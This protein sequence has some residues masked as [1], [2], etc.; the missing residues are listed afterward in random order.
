V[1]SSRH[2]LNFEHIDYEIREKDLVYF[3]NSIDQGC[4]RKANQT[5]KS[6][7]NY[8]IKFESNLVELEIYYNSKNIRSFQCGCGAKSPGKYCKHA[9]IAS[10]WHFQN[11]HINVTP[12]SV[13]F[14][15]KSQSFSSFSKEDLSYVLT[16]LCQNNN[17]NK[18]WVHFIL[19]GRT[20]AEKPYLK[21]TQL[22]LEINH[23]LEASS[24]NPATRMKNKLEILEELYQISFYH[25]NHSNI[26]EATESL[27]AGIHFIHSTADYTIFKNF[28][29]L[30]QMNDKFHTAF[31]QFCQLIVAPI[32]LSK[33]HKL[34]YEC[35]TS[36]DYLV[37]T[38][39]SN[40][41]ER[42]LLKKTFQQQF[43]KEG[44]EHLL[45]KIY[46]NIPDDFKYN[47]LDYLYQV[48]SEQLIQFLLKHEI[49]S[50]FYTSLNWLNSRKVSLPSIY[51]INY[52]KNIYAIAAADLKKYIGHL[53]LNLLNTNDQNALD[54]F[55]LL[56]YQDSK[57]PS[58]LKL[59]FNGNYSLETY[60]EAKEFLQKSQGTNLL[61]EKTLLDL[62]YFSQQYTIFFN[63][64]R[65]ST[66][67]HLLEKYD[68][69]LPDELA[70]EYIKIYISFYEKYLNEHAGYQ[71]N[72][73]LE[74]SLRRIRNNFSKSHY[75]EFL[76]TIKKLFPDRKLIKQLLN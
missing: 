16:A 22:L 70:V 41:F 55:L 50:N 12:T 53:Y 25:Y 2:P 28:T 14:K 64:L 69:D 56:F 23:F 42:L 71:A 8:L 18:Q 31:I 75:L 35:A 54:V 3:K 11:I 45:Q 38:R 15:N 51:L 74:F 72:Q 59:Y 4:I 21:Y 68:L 19:T 1:H 63:E 26:E 57:D 27:L 52:Y 67:L 9:L 48:N 66:D 20:I 10:I 47:I 62:S 33:I 32:A 5:G 76:N 36:K 37:L 65:T 24:K 46:F 60:N 49:Q 40:L 44:F 6:R 29:K 73:K 58:F 17:N 39:N 61:P 13:N 43:N 34:T 7:W 30:I